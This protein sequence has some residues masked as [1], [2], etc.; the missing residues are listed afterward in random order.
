LNL[1]LTCIFLQNMNINI[2][3]E[4]SQNITSPEVGPDVTDA[5]N[6]SP[7]PSYCQLY[8]TSDLTTQTETNS[9]V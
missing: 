6:G 7:P 2:L 4:L 5:E 9:S 1:G 8:V 3:Q